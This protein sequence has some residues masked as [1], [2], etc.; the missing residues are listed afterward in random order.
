MLKD[1][2]VKTTFTAADAHWN[3]AIPAGAQMDVETLLKVF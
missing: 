2:V 1:I 3:R